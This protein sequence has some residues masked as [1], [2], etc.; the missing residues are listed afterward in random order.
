[1]VVVDNYPGWW[2]GT[3]WYWNPYYSTWSFIPGA[4]YFDNPW[5]FGFYSPAYLGV[6]GF[7]YGYYGGGFYRGGRIWRGGVG[8]P[9]VVGRTGAGAVAARPS[10]AA[11]SMGGMRAPA[12]GG[13][14][15]RFGGGRR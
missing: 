7:P 8:R 12:M 2:G 4:G 13:G 14:G 11:P 9:T 10:F 6:Y 5:G 1:M 3:G 15:A